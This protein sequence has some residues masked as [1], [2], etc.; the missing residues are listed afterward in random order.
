MI[1][2][3]VFILSVGC[4]GD[5]LCKQTVKLTAPILQGLI[6]RV[7]LFSDIDKSAVFTG[8]FQDLPPLV[9]KGKHPAVG[10]GGF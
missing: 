9:V 5:V 8:F 4:F 6:R 3:P 1:I 7:L 10:D 2:D